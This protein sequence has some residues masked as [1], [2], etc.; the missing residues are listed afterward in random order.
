V[1]VPLEPKV[2][3]I[4]FNRRPDAK[5]SDPAYLQRF[6]GVYELA[7]QEVTFALQGNVLT[8]TVPGQPL[9]EL[10]PDRGANST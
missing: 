6:V 4:V 2:P 7:G 9:H 1:A 3:E 5:L 8:V 10:V